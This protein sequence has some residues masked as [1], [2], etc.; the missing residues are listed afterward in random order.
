MQQSPTLMVMMGERAWT[1]EA[2]HLACALARHEVGTVTLVR[3]IPV[4]HP[5]YL[6]TEFAC[7][8]PTGQECRDMDEYMQLI[9]AYGV[10]SAEMIF[11]YINL[12]D[13]LCDAAE[14]LEASYVF[15]TLPQSRIPYWHRFQTHLLQTR[16]ARQNRTL[17]TL[18]PTSDAA[19]RPGHVLITTSKPEWANKKEVSR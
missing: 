9:A 10:D 6:G 11:Q 19:P 5:S 12:T 3:M 8:E 17:C 18:E 4:M 1:L 13:A 7:W 14:Q 15:A 2:L 16:L